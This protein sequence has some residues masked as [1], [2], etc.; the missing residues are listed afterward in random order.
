MQVLKSVGARTHPWR[1]PVLTGKCQRWCHHTLQHSLYQNTGRISG[2]RALRVFRGGVYFRSPNRAL[3]E[4]PYM[5]P[6]TLCWRSMRIRSARMRSTEGNP[7]VVVTLGVNTWVSPLP[8]QMHTI[9]Y[10]QF[11]IIVC[12]STWSGFWVIK[13]VTTY[14]PM[15]FVAIS[16]LLIKV[17]ILQQFT[18]RIKETATDHHNISK[19]WLNGIWN[20]VLD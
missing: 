16:S 15:T 19:L 7:P 10:Q 13:F 5:L 1:T 4:N 9:T 11:T 12:A 6:T 17:T 3:R 2:W 8:F 18:E 20:S 14:M